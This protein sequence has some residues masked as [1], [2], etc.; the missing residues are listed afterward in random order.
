MALATLSLSLTHSL[1][2]DWRCILI[3]TIEMLINALAPHALSGKLF[4]VSI[5]DKNVVFSIAHA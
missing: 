3:D 4:L 1:L 2:S 5:F